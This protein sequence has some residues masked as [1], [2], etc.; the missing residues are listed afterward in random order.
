LVY[1]LSYFLSMLKLKFLK[2]L[3]SN[4][5]FSRKLVQK[6]LTTNAS[7]QLFLKRIQNTRVSQLQ[8]VQNIKKNKLF[9][10]KKIK[11]VFGSDHYLKSQHRLSYILWRLRFFP[12]RLSAK[13]A[14]KRGAVFVNNFS[15]RNA[16]SFLKPG[17]LVCI[18]L[19]TYS[20]DPRFFIDV[21]NGVTMK[22]N[23]L[24]GCEV[25]FSTHSFVVSYLEDFLFCWFY[26]RYARTL[27]VF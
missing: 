16:L 12:S 1:S 2:K 19:K 8:K 21:T 22:A 17:D 24:K 27:V 18:H 7:W 26:R 11:V 4:P 9:F 5:C 6:C 3:K 25:S 10:Q 13:K 23:I 14:I 20:T 15:Q